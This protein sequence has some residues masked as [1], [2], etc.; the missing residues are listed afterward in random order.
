VIEPVTAEGAVIVTGTSTVQLLASL[1]VTTY[2]PAVS[3]PKVPE[4][5]KAPPSREY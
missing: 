2:P 4:P 5:P 3:V 1:T